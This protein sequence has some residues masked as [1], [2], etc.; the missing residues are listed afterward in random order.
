MSTL[1]H[2]ISCNSLSSVIAS[3]YILESDI[4]SHPGYSKYQ[5]RKKEKQEKELVD[6]FLFC[7][8]VSFSPNGHY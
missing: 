1:G 2:Y 5:K 8:P 3:K 6:L 7:R 4:D